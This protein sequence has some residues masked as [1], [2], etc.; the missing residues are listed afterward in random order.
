MAHRFNPLS[1]LY[2]ATGVFHLA[3]SRRRAPLRLSPRQQSILAL[4]SRGMTD[5]EI[6][7]QLGLS[8]HT[9]RT[10]LG[11]VYRENKLHNKA[12]AVAAWLRFARGE[13][14]D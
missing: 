3:S 6:A 9:V 8:V 14:R 5:K 7:A 11:R 10:H 4:A 1:T 12:E 2:V 13:P